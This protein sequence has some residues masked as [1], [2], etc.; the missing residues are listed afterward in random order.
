MS[1]HERVIR[2]WAVLRRRVKAQRGFTIIECM[3]VLSIMGVISIGMSELVI[4]MF[5]SQARVVARAAQLQTADELKAF[6]TRSIETATEVGLTEGVS[7]D[8]LSVAGDQVLLTLEDGRCVRLMYVQAL[9]EVQAR[10]GE[11]C[12]D[13]KPVRGPNED[14]EDTSPTETDDGNGVWESGESMYD[15]A[16]DASSVAVGKA[17]VL[18]SRVELGAGPAFTFEDDNGEPVDGVDTNANASAADDGFYAVAADREQIA[19]VRV[20]GLVVVPGSTKSLTLDARFW[21]AGRRP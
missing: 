13:V 15:P 7:T 10:T 18:A 2:L 16:L 3:I 21:L 19:A 1:R 8:E 20:R 6:G 17:T 5:T 9:K 4:S 12:D 11:S 14:R